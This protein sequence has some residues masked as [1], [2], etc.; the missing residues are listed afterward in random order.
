MDG[1]ATRAAESQSGALSMVAID[2]MLLDVQVHREPQ[3]LD[4]SLW[5][6]WPDGSGSCITQ[7]LGGTQEDDMTVVQV[8]HTTHDV[9]RN[10]TAAVPQGHLAARNN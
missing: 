8:P 10:C 3:S 2:A 5:S 7:L 6:S 9:M 1:G 4:V